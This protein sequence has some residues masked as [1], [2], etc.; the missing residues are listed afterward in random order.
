MR[1]LLVF[2]LLVALAGCS[3]EEKKPD[4]S[5]STDQTD[6]GA[7][8][9]NDNKPV[10]PTPKGEDA[11]DETSEPGAADKP[12]DDADKSGDDADKPADEADKSGDDADKSGD[13]ADKPAD[14]ADKSGD[15]VDKSG[16]DADKSGDDADKSADDADKSADDADKSADDAD[17]SGDDVDSAD[18][19][20]GDDDSDEPGDD[21]DSISSV[22][23]EFDAAMQAFTKQYRATRSAKE[24]SELAANKR[25]KPD[26]FAE[27]L[28]PLVEKMPK[29]E[30]AL[31]AL[32]WISRRAK[33][34]VANKAAE[35]LLAHHLDADEVIQ[36]AVSKM[37]GPPTQSNQEFLQQLIDKSSVEQ[38][39]LK[40]VATYARVMALKNGQRTFDY[41]ANQL[42]SATETMA[43]EEAEFIKI[44]KN[45]DDFVES[46]TEDSRT[47]MES[48]KLVDGR[49]LEDLIVEIDDQFADVV[50]MTRGE[51]EITIG[52][53]CTGTLFELRNLLI[54][55]T[56][57][58][59]EAEDL[60]GQS[61]KLSDYRGK[62]VVIDF[63]GDW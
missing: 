21:A 57:P 46:L 20:S 49:G 51:K 8:S 58:D 56:A 62:V 42:K 10:T 24:R 3:G 48:G 13:D 4:E 28:L 33:G 29:S 32:T 30:D 63:W 26:S 15:D 34:D 45:Y 43:E 37:Y 22:M 7:A 39:R 16:D 53:K 27:R 52:E 11:K 38:K 9:V 19:D 61:F 2:C 60:D 36:I 5:R 6:K 44:K 59:I 25:P 41:Y 50:L 23:T 18:D 17:K 31:K 14:E 55:N 54:G 40:G 35:I 12:A 47:F 1:K